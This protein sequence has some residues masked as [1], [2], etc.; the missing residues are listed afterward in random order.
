VGYEAATLRDIAARAGV[1]PALLYRYFPGKR[2]VLLALYDDLSLD[3][4]RSAAA[5]PPGKWRDRFLE[6]LR[7][8]LDVLAPHRD[9][10]AALVPVLVGSREEG[11]FAP[12]TAFSRERVQGAFVA[13]VA[14]AKDAPKDEDAAALG[15]VLYLVHLAVLLFWLLDRSAAQSATKR[16]VGLVERTLPAFSLAFRLRALRDVVRGID[17]AATAAFLGRVA[18]AAG[19]M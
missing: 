14:G 15:R 17:G 7:A 13:A 12:A 18:P 1:S 9:T 6:T 10:L 5:V 3:F 8:S 4:S 16:L 2:A 19:A 11:L